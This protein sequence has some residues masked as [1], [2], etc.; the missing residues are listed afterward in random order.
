MSWAVER[1]VIF[2]AE[3]DRFA[4]AAIALCQPVAIT[5]GGAAFATNGQNHLDK[6]SEES[7]ER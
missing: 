5:S 7:G 2:L 3:R 6:P 1:R 4:T